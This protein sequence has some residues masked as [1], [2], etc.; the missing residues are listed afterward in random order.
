MRQH[1]LLGRGRFVHKHLL[2]H[3]LHYHHLHHY[4]KGHEHNIFKQFG[5]LSLGEGRHHAHHKQ[6]KTLKFK[7]F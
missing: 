3:A 1:I 5:D 4:G 7:N 2:H 6:K